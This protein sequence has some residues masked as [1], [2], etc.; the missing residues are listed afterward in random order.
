MTARRRYLAFALVAV[1]L[2]GSLVLHRWPCSRP[3]DLTDLY[4]RVDTLDRE[5]AAARQAPDPSDT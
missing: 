1:L 4:S 5:V 3:V 2:A